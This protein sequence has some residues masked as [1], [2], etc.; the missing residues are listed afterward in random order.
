MVREFDERAES[1]GRRWL[2]KDAAKFAEDLSVNLHLTYPDPVCAMTS[3]GI[4]SSHRVKEVLKECMEEKFERKV[5]E[6]E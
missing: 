2:V 5:R 3:E 6:L 4:L 1:L